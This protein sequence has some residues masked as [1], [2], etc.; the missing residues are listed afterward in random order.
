MDIKL[1]STLPLQTPDWTNLFSFKAP[2]SDR[3]PRA[4]VWV[5]AHTEAEAIEIAKRHKFKI[6]L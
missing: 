1:I 4:R 5:L 6:K 2:S 3:C